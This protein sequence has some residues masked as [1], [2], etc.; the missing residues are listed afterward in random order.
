VAAR[1]R[2]QAGLHAGEGSEGEFSARARHV[3]A[4]RQA[5]ASL[6]EAA[7]EFSGERLELAAEQLHRGHDALGEITG[8]VSADDMLGHIFSTFC[9]GKRARRRS[10]IGS[11]MLGGAA[12]QGAGGG[13]RC[14]RPGNGPSDPLSGRCAAQHELGI[15]RWRWP[16]IRACR[17]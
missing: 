7:A 15:E 14:R 17:G 10:A 16:R 1:L 5:L 8:R 2:E 11:G 13:S 6:N 4:L 3:Q 12:C 9:I